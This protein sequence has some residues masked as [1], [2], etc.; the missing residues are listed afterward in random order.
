MSITY[1]FTCTRHNN[2]YM[3]GNISVIMESKSFDEPK[4][5][6]K[7]SKCLCSKR[8]GRNER[9]PDHGDIDKI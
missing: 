8:I 7:V 4:E 3:N 5:I 9:C 1:S 2:L 6:K